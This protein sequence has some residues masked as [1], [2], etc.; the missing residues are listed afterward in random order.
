MPCGWKW[1]AGTQYL[2]ASS[3]LGYNGYG[4]GARSSNAPPQPQEYYPGRW[5]KYL[6]TAFQPRVFNNPPPSRYVGYNPS[7]YPIVQPGVYRSYRAADKNTFTPYSIVGAHFNSQQD[8]LIPTRNQMAAG[9]DPN[10]QTL[11]PALY[12]W[13]HHYPARMRPEALRS[14]QAKTLAGIGHGGG[15]CCD[16]CAKGTG[17]TTE[18]QQQAAKKEEPCCDSCAEGKACSGCGEMKENCPYGGCSGKG[19]GKASHRRGKRSPLPSHRTRTRHR[20]HGIGEKESWEYGAPPYSFPYS[21]ASGTDPSQGPNPYRTGAA[22]DLN[23]WG[24]YWGYA[25]GFQGG[26]RRSPAPVNQSSFWVGY[27][28]NLMM[29]TYGRVP[30]RSVQYY[31]PSNFSGGQSQGIGHRAFYGYH[32]FPDAG[33]F[34]PQYQYR[35]R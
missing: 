27:P 22:Y 18:C 29:E 11:Q 4:M 35:G 26:R 16:S 34:E 7:A 31:L 20:H 24:L 14:E 21:D 17:C 23:P 10:Y 28:N 33:V 13:G 9:Y 32:V 12:A 3:R 5:G 8:Q 25:K 30:T 6:D 1:K 15:A 19:I 2:R